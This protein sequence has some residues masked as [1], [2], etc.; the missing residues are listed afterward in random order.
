[1][2]RQTPYN[3]KGLNFTCIL[4]ST[5]F[6]LCLPFSIALAVQYI[7][8]FNQGLLSKD[9]L[10][11]KIF[12][13]VLLVLVIA[14]GVA[15]VANW[16]GNDIYQIRSSKVIAEIRYDIYQQHAKKI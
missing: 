1:M 4:S 16:L 6:D 9:D 2:E 10:K 15:S 12:E 11:L 14:N 5:L 7:L 13:E 8:D 3:V